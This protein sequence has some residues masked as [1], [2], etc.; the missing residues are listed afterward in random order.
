M[1]TALTNTSLFSTRLIGVL[2]S[3]YLL[4]ACALGPTLPENLNGQS[5]V[6]LGFTADE[7]IPYDGGTLYTGLRISKIDGKPV[8]L[9]SLKK[10]DYRILPPGKHLLEGYCYWQ[11]RSIHRFEDDL[12][13]PAVI[14]LETRPNTRYTLQSEIDE[15]KNRC[16]VSIV[17]TPHNP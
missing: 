6:V 12:Q 7:A 2:L 16:E 9:P 8:G 15:Y 14:E 11:L 1:K 5:I 13:E 4:G 3:V 10:Y 17:E